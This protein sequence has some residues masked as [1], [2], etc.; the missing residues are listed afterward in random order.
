M[1]NIIFV[2]F[3]CIS[4]IADASETY[5]AC[6]VNGSSQSNYGRENFRPS[7]V[8][9]EITN[10]SN[11]LSI[12]ID[13]EDNYIASA[14][15]GKMQNYQASNLSD[16]NKF[17]LTGT[18]IPTSGSIKSQT[19]NININRISGLITVSTQTDFNNGN[20]IHSSYSGTCNKVANKKF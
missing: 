8:T 12:I 10:Y 7:Q 6:N 13:G 19:V 1:K 16:A 5:L 3:L 4:S 2:I 17:Q 11:F 9:V 15:T 20:F 14:T 18:R